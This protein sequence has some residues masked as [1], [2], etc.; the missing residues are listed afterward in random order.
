ML[1]KPSGMIE[2]IALGALDLDCLALSG[3]EQDDV[4]GL[5]KI[6]SLVVDSCDWE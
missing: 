3:F 4:D 2:V 5:Q 1:Y 6:A